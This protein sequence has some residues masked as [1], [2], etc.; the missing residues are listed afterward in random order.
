MALAHS[1]ISQ[2]SIIQPTVVLPP[3]AGAY[4]LGGLCLSALG[5]CT[6]NAMVSDFELRSRTVVDGNEFVEVSANYSA[7]I[8]TN[9]GGD[10]GAFLGHLSLSGTA[11]FLYVG[12]DPAVNP[13]G[14]FPTEL[15]D[16]GFS[17]I[18]NGNTFEVKR[19][20][21]NTSAGST[22]IL[23]H[24]FVPPITYQVNGSLEI[25]ALYSFNGSPFLPAPPRTA[26]VNPVPAAPEP[27][28]LGLVGMGLVT[29]GIRAWR[30]RR[31]MR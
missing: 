8:F 22:T 14:T 11:H 19:N 16:F 3:L 31:A 9:D 20:P 17:G 18:L 6:Q 29:I 25:F 24:T 23:P 1:T 4:T 13:L 12:R 21:A 27:A 26:E 10:P 15:T 5:R 30:R 7:D 2:A 28:T